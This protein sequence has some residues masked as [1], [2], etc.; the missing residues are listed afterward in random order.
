MNKK[1]NK[2]VEIRQKVKE[3]QWKKAQRADYVNDMENLVQ[4]T[5]EQ[6]TTLE[7]K[8]ELET[9]PLVSFS[10]RGEGEEETVTMVC[11]EF[12]L[13]EHME[14]ITAYA[15]Y[16]LIKSQLQIALKQGMSEAEATEFVKKLITINYL[17]S[18]DL[19][20]EQIKTA[21]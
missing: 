1:R 14:S 18:V 10:I 6:N 9:M 21:E 19:V 8:I 15:V 17:E 11:N 4:G 13:P 3:K 12:A 16:L 2:I 20:L 7:E 5:L